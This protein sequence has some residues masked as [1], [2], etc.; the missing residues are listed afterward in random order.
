VEIEF[1]LTEDD[2]IAFH[3][4][5]TEH[6]PAP[7]KPVSTRGLW[8]I[9]V[10]LSLIV[11]LSLTA[12]GP[13]GNN[14]YYFYSCLALLLGT[15][16]LIFSLP[17]MKNRQIARSVEADLEQAKKA[18][19]LGPQRLVI[20]PEGLTVMVSL[21]AGFVDWRGIEKVVVTEDHAIF[22]VTTYSAH[23]VPKRAFPDELAFMEFVTA[24]KRFRRAAEEGRGT[25][26]SYR[27]AGRG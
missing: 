20:K 17:R 6:P 8:L 26:T 15:L 11:G 1:T 24:V 10:L 25:N 14:P 5:H 19:L 21:R 16:S 2:L 27:A 12:G 3:K 23:V 22:Y 9:V 13:R 4:Y 7:T 18:R